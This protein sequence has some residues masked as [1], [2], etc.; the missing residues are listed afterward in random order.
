MITLFSAIAQKNSQ[1]FLAIYV[2][3]VLVER[4]DKS[5]IDSIKN[6]LNAQ[7]MIKDFDE[8]CNLLGIK[9]IKQPV[10]MILSQRK[11]ALDLIKE[12]KCE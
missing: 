12:F 4:I 8:L 1:V 3:N 9:T 10:G 5:E 7:F 6:F 2:D 11:Y